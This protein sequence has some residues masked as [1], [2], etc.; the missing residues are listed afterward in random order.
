[1]TFVVL[2]GHVTVNA[3]GAFEHGSPGE[4]ITT[5]IREA[6]TSIDLLDLEAEAF[7]DRMAEAGEKPTNY[8]EIIDRNRGTLELDPEQRVELGPNNC[9]A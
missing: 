2:P 3:D 8:E 6:R 9:S 4:S 1:V 7:I 5:T